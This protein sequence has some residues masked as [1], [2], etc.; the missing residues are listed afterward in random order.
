MP[1][2]YAYGYRVCG[3]PAVYES[4]PERGAAS[5]LVKE[6]LQIMK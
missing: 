4:Q 3:V 2:T 6:T 1:G 5:I